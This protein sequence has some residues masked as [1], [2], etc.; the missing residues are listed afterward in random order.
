VWIEEKIGDVSLFS[1]T[2]KEENNR[3]GD[4][5]SD[6]AFVGSAESVRKLKRRAALVMLVTRE[7]PCPSTSPWKCI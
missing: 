7:I 2:T 1:M 3:R 5:G 4:N 6:H